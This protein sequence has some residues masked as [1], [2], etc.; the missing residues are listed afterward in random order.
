MPPQSWVARFDEPNSP[1]SPP[2]SLQTGTIR[3]PWPNRHRA[4]GR[5]GRT[6]TSWSVKLACPPY[7]PTRPR[8]SNARNVR[9]DGVTEKGCHECDFDTVAQ[10]TADNHMSYIEDTTSRSPDN[11]RIHFRHVRNR[12][13]SPK[14]PISRTR[15]AARLRWRTHTW[16]R[17]PAPASVPGHS[18]TP[19]EQVADEI[20][21]ETV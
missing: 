6:R 9:R 21:K 15:E 20:E 2:N 5:G 3:S 16:S 4:A 7:H 8:G 14:H 1:T 18:R 10:L 17:S 12:S 19:D 11:H 13:R